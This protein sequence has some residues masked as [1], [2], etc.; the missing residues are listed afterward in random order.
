MRFMYSLQQARPDVW[1]KDKKHFSEKYINPKKYEFNFN[2][3]L[4][5]DEFLN[6]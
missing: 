2:A 6:S 3:S 4:K 1:L 5:A